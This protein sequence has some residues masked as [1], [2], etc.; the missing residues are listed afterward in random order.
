MVKVCDRW[1]SVSSV[2]QHEKLIA[3][4]VE[5]KL[6]LGKYCLMD[7]TFFTMILGRYG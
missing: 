5:R 6:L 2:P 7:W 1:P 4:R 3:D